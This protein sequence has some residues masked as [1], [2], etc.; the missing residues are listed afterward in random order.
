MRVLV[1]GAQGMLG[2]ALMK[3]LVRQSDNV[4]GTT[5]D[6]VA[7]LIGGIDISD[8]IDVL[9]ALDVAK[10]EVI[11]NCAGIVKSECHRYSTDRVQAVNTRAP[12]A[13]ADIARR[14]GVRLV[15][16]ST[17]CVFSGRRGSY[18]EKDLTDAEDLYGQSK[19]AGEVSDRS[20]CLT[21]RTSF[22]GRDPRRGRGLLEWLLAAR[23]TV[24]G[25]VG[26]HWSGLSAPELAR[27][28]TL[29]LATPA[30]SGLYHVVGPPVS[31]ADLLQVLV[32]EMRLP[33]RVKRVDGER[34]DRTLNGSRFVDVTGY[35]PPGWVEMARELVHA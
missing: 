27:A 5:Q 8:P 2:T 31:K 17:D 34:V 23:D 14:R 7:G 11:V 28:L 26:A 3:H 9:R 18:R 15:H 6:T 20:D 12:H 29:A 1:L 13:I 24:P 25:F 19:A 21:I 32:Q 4:F 10:P 30:L 33:C 16:V 22:I 35:A